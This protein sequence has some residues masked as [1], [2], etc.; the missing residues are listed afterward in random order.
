MPKQSGSSWLRWQR[1]KF[2][3]EDV[4]DYCVDDD[5]RFYC[6]HG[7]ANLEEHMAREK[8]PA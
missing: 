1:A 8:V 4:P 5:G 6:E 2:L 7:C 3:G